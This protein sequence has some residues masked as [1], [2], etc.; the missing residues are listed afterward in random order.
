MEELLDLGPHTIE[1]A[2]QSVAEAEQQF[3]KGD[4]KSNEEVIAKIKQKFY[5]TF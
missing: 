1:E 2:Y 4:F 3:I 5:D